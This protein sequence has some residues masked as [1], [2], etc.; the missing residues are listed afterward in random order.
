MVSQSR[1]IKKSGI[2][3]NRKMKSLN[4]CD[5]D[6]DP[7]G[8]DH[9]SRGLKG[10]FFNHKSEGYIK[11]SLDLNEGKNENVHYS[12]L[13]SSLTVTAE[14]NQLL[15]DKRLLY[16]KNSLLGS[17]EVNCKDGEN[18]FIGNC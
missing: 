1:S 9:K 7:I 5:V 10:L 2:F 13:H 14:E 8:G 12:S 16:E 11:K 3:K 15:L 18:G 6:N 17:L 4:D